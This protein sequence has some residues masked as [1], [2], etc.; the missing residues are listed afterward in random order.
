MKNLKRIAELLF[1]MM[2]VAFMAFSQTNR[3]DSNDQTKNS[4]KI[5]NVNIGPNYVD[6]NNDGIC[7]NRQNNGNKQ[8]RGKNFVDK[9][10]DGI[11]DNYQNKKLNNKKCCGKGH[12]NRNSNCCGRGNGN[13]CRH[14]HGWGN[15]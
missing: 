3:I 10:N 11:C 6:K 15:R 9:N 1:V 4:A 2:L 8:L 5:S 13:G 7:D 14:R 12:G